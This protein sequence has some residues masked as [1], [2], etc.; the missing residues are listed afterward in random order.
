MEPIV[1]GSAGNLVTAV[2]EKDGKRLILDGG[3]TRLYI[4]WDTAGT[5]RYVK[6]AAAWLV[7]VEKFGDAVVSNDILEEEE[8]IEELEGLLEE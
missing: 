2:Y 6:N 4:N 8:E 1:Y 7:N 3:F 5:G